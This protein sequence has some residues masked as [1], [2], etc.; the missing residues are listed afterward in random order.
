M[1][2]YTRHDCHLC[3]RAHTIATT[4]AADY[5]L[6]VQ[7][8]DV[9]SSEALRAL[10]GAK[11]PVITVGGQVVQAG[12]VSEY[13]LRRA[14]GRPRSARALAGLGMAFVREQTWEPR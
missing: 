6:T 9:D 2:L 10:Y 8:I 7:V 1:V 14:L 4:V 12:R 11:V 5:A 3:E 13:R